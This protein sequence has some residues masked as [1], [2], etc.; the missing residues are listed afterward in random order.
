MQTGR[1]TIRSVLETIVKSWKIYNERDPRLPDT[2]A[3]VIDR[4][5][6]GDCGLVGIAANHILKERFQVETSI[7]VN[8]NHC[9]IVYQ[10]QDFDTTSP[11]GYV[12]ENRAN[13][14][15]VRTPGEVLCQIELT[16]EQACD[17]WMPCD[18]FGAYLIKGLCDGYGVA[19]PGKLQHCLDN[20]QRYDITEMVEIYETQARKVAVSINESNKESV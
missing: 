17:E 7:W 13:D 14:V 2:Y 10:G 19:F 15:W 3:G 11:Q 6:S 9:W 1:D 5:N 8:P 4:I 16:F 18:T 20:A 12:P